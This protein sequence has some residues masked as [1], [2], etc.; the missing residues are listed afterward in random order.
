MTEPLPPL[1]DVLAGRYRIERLLGA[2]GMGLVYRARDLLHEQFDASSGDIAVKILGEAFAETPD[3]N[4]LLYREFALTRHLRH[5]GVVQVFDFETD[6][7]CQ[8]A[9]IT[10]ELMQACRWTGCFANGP[11]ACR[12]LSCAISPSNCWTPGTCPRTGRAAR[13]SKA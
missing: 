7:A 13:R 6:A 3:A 2:G 10:M 8:R 5:P 11:S 12:G 9:F 1:P 4:A